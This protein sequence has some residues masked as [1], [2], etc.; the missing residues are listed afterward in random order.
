[1]GDLVVGESVGDLV[2]GE[3]VGDL[4]VGESV[5]LDVEF[6]GIHNIT[7]LGLNMSRLRAT[8]VHTKK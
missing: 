8:N 4:V 5:G 6:P 2:V 3:S 7:T 1:M